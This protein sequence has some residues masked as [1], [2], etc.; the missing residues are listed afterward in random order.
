M[1]ELLIIEIFGLK[2][3]LKNGRTS[4]KENAL[5]LCL[6]QIFFWGG[7]THTCNSKNYDKYTYTIIRTQLKLKE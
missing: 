4:I 6:S 2:S 5:F 1:S 3:P 7:G